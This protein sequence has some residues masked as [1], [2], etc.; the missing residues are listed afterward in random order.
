[1]IQDAVIAQSAFWSLADQS[2]RGAILG[3]AE[4]VT[5]EDGNGRED[6]NQMKPIGCETLSMA[7]YVGS[8]LGPLLQCA[9]LLKEAE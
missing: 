4:I 9:V 1:M 7:I 5:A 2:I 3:R 6:R 8:S